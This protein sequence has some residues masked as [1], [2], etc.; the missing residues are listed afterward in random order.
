MT[1]PMADFHLA[2]PGTVDEA[3]AACAKHPGSRYVAGGTDLL[4]NMRRGIT[5]PDQLVDLSGIDELTA[6]TTDAQGMTIGAGVTIATLARNTIV[7]DKYRA[8]AQAAAA[9]AGPAHRTMGTVGGNLCLDTRCIYY[10]QSEWWRSANAYC[11]KNRGETCHVAPQ[12]QRCHAAYSGDLAPALLVL[13]AEIDIAGSQGQRRIPLSELYVEDGKA[14]LTLADGELIVAVHLPAKAP[15][16]RYEKVRT[17]GAIDFPLAGVAVA[18]SVKGKT[19][20][21]L[22]IALTGT[23][24]RP[25]LL[26]GTDA[27]AGQ[28]LDDKLLQAIDR[29]VQKQVQPMRTTLA[30]A[31]YRRLVAAA[32]ARRLTTQLFAEASA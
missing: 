10:N 15:A 7:V 30:S 3:V 29:A 19:I 18:L 31:N 11:L 12:G 26:E 1:A 8:L 17:R 27:F 23:N 16:S 13:G 21:S 22:R 32:L 24:S 20:G 5:S 6:I 4:V 9:I 14:H 25:F 28:A 2:Q